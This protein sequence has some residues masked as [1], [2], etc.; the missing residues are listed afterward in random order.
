MR[1]S[2]KIMGINVNIHS[3]S[4]P[5]GQV[6]F[7]LSQGFTENEPVDQSGNPPGNT[8][9]VNN[10]LYLDS[11]PL[12]NDLSKGP[13][14]A[15]N[16]AGKRER[17]NAYFTLSSPDAFPYSTLKLGKGGKPKSKAVC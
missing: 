11:S 2:P 14:A 10:K 16:A 12:Q 7:S 4:H 1:S 6:Y 5:T 17:K 15:Q 8:T 9:T 3:C 13:S